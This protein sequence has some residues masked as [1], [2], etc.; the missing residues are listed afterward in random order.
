[1]RTAAWTDKLWFS[2][3]LCLLSPIAAAC[4]NSIY[5]VTS[6]QLLLSCKGLSQGTFALHTACAGVSQQSWIAEGFVPCCVGAEAPSLPVPG[7]AQAHSPVLIDWVL[8]LGAEPGI[9]VV[10]RKAWYR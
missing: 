3:Q 7:G 1:M 2:W 6:V 4:S 5:F 9:W 10:S 8:E